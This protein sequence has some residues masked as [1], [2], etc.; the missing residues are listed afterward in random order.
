MKRRFDTIHFAI[1]GALDQPTGGYRY[2]A[3]IIMGLRRHGHEVVVHELAGRHPEPDAVAVAAAQSCNDASRDGILVI[4]GLALPSFA[5]LNDAAVI[6]RAVVLVHHPL[7]LETGIEPGARRRFAAIERDAFV[8]CRRIV[9]TS[10]ATARGL[11]GYGVDRTKVAIVTP[12]LRPTSPV[13]TRRSRGTVAILCVASITPRKNHRALLAALAGLRDRCWR[14]ACVG[15]T[16]RD[17]RALSQLRLARHSFNLRRR[18]VITGAVPEERVV[19]HFARADLFAL[20][21][22]HEGYGMAFAEAIAS[23]LPVIG[24]DAGA[25]GDVVPHEAGTLVRHIAGLRAALRR[26]LF[27]PDIRRR[28]RATARSHRQRY[29]DPSTQA[30]KFA[31][32]LGLDSS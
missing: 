2:D 11:W 5:G 22:L 8:H 28:M 21:S 10:L 19:S 12:P 20:A 25:V 29:P 3:A 32:A 30:K 16:D 15:P 6:E 18:V 9:T 7:P 13:P 27:H 26:V 14:L 4:D 24:Y 17:S 23:G 1:P 31:T